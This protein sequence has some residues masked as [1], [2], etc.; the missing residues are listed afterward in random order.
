M[1]QADQ[2]VSARELQ[3]YLSKTGI[4][5]SY[6]LFSLVTCRLMILT[7]D[8]NFSGDMD[9]N[10]FQQMWN[11]VNE[12]KAKFMSMDKDRSGTLAVAELQQAISSLGYS[13]S[14]LAFHCIAK[15]YGENGLIAFDDF[16]SIIIKLNHVT[17]HFRARDVS[18]NG[19]ATFQYDDFIQIT[20]GL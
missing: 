6:Q 8:R 11:V 17:G 2:R 14:S 20:M 18:K 3:S 1:S 7:L 19:S 12:A 9:F 16:I 15:R 5:G 13:L 10:E 4:T